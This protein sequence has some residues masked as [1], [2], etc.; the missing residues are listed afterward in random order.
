MLGFLK[1]VDSISSLLCNVHFSCRSRHRLSSC[2]LDSQHHLYRL[3]LRVNGRHI[4]S[5]SYR[6]LVHKLG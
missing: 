2:L 3:S 1:S 4:A 5:Q 6:L